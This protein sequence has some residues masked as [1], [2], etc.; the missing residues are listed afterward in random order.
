MEKEEKKTLILP[1]PVRKG[2]I[3]HAN[4]VNRMTYIEKSSVLKNQSV[5]NAGVAFVKG[6]NR[7]FKKKNTN[8]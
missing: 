1:F 5:E 7:Y 3:A 4:V 6:A 8:I 2:L